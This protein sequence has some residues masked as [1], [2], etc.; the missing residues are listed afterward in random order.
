MSMEEFDLSDRFVQLQDCGHVFEVSGLDTWMQTEQSESGVCGILPKKCPEC[1]KPVIRSLR[2]G[3]DVKAKLRQIENVKKHIIGFEMTNE[4]IRHLRERRFGEAIKQFIA[5]IEQNMASFQTYFGMGCALCSQ[6]K[7]G[8]AANLFHFI[9]KHSSL[10]NGA[11]DV[12]SVQLVRK[13][14]QQLSY[15]DDGCSPLEVRNA[16]RAIIQRTLSDE[17]LLQDEVGYELAIK[18]LIQWASALSNLRQFPAAM[19]AC[20][21]VLEKEPDNKEAAETLRLASNGEKRQ[22]VEVMMREVGGRG[23]WYQCPNG[24]YY[25]VGE[26][27]GPMQLST[28]PDCKATVGGQSHTPAQGNT[29]ASIDGSSHSAW[30]D[31]VGLGDLDL[32]LGI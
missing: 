29:H 31:Q 4:G 8:H 16:L 13:R 17:P 1:R 10:V 23:H 6:S 11:K 5:T 24:H 18:A 27:G 12:E 20:Q 15:D 7:F 21:I 30:S 25:V 14:A 26:C 2:Y 19:K 9:V 32:D 22:V 3:N 28:C